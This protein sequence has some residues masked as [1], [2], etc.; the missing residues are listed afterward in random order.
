[1]TDLFLQNLTPISQLNRLQLKETGT[2]DNE[3]SYKK[4][5]T[6]EVQLEIT[7]LTCN[8]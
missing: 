1:M 8:K 3:Q 2:K 5:K 7:S 6:Y 4:I